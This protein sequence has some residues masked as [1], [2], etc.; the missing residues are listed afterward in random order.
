[1]CLPYGVPV[2]L[3][4]AEKQRIP[5]RGSTFSLCCL[6]S[7]RPGSATSPKLHLERQGSW[8]VSLSGMSGDHGPGPDQLL[9]LS[10][11]R[12]VVL[13]SYVPPPTIRLQQL[14]SKPV[15]GEVGPSGRRPLPPLQVER[16]GASA[17]GP[18]LLLQD[19]QLS[20]GLPTT[21]RSMPPISAMSQASSLTSSVLMLGGPPMPMGS[22]LVACLSPGATPTDTS[23][24]GEKTCQIHHTMRLHG[25]CCSCVCMQAASHCLSSLFMPHISALPWPFAQ[26]MHGAGVWCGTP[27]WKSTPR[28]HCR[29]QHLPQGGRSPG[30]RTSSVAGPVGAG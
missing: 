9:V 23:R 29:W 15:P 2:S 4:K 5:P 18:A 20:K 19:E 8:A 11:G 25:S 30:A 28:C 26:A 7:Y 24:L 21:S 10:D 17:S 6:E 14:T 16:G 22:M 13:L 3:G 27:C 12:S 1:M